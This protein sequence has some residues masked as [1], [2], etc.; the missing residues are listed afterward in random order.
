VIIA[1]YWWRTAVRRSWR[2]IAG[3]VLLC[4]LLG[5]VALAAV[6]GA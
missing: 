6:A 5:A 2:Q 1:L 4:G 3:L